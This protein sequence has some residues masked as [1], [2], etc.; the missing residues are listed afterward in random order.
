M[1]KIHILELILVT[2]TEN[3]SVVTNDTQGHQ[4]QQTHK[5]AVGTHM[6]AHHNTKTT[7]LYLPDD[8]YTV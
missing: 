2:L 1:E 5:I 8:G 7:P 6:H 3:T 4:E